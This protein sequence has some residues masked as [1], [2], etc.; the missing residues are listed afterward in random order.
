MMRTVLTVLFAL[1]AV[2]AR[3]QPSFDCTSND[4]RIRVTQ[5]ERITVPCDTMYVMTDGTM[6]QFYIERDKMR[7]EAELADREIEELRGIILTQDSLIAIH[8]EDVRSL[9]DHLTFTQTKLDTLQLRLGE[10]IELTDEVIGIARRK[11]TL[12]YIAGGLGGAALGI[13]VGI[14]VE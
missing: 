8:R 2:Q 1:F 9:E 6:R 5:S 7:R 3:S 4:L 10:S 14:L 11:N 12:A 13:V